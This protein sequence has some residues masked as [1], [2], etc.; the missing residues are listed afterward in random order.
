MAPALA[1]SW[2]DVSVRS[3]LCWTGLLLLS[4]R[5]GS[6]RP[7]LGTVS[8]RVDA[9]VR[10]AASPD[11]TGPDGGFEPG[12]RV[13]LKGT[14][15][16]PDEVYEGEVM[17][18]G[19]FIVCAG[20]G[21]SCSSSAEAAGATVFD[22]EGVIAP[23][24]IDT[25]NHI[26]FD[27]FDDE[28]WLP[29]RSYTNHDMWP[30]EERYAAM[31]DVKQCLEDASQG[32]P[33]WCPAKYDGEGDLKCELNKWGELKGLIAGTTS[34]V[35]LPGTSAACFASLARSV[36]SPQNGLGQDRIQTSA[37]F[38][39]SRSSAD[40]VCA[41][42]ADG[43]TRA[44]LVHAGEGIDA[45][46]LRE[47]DQ[48]GSA[49]TDPGC[50]YDAKT[51]I[52]HGT[53]FTSAQFDAMAAAGM[54][55]T[56]SPASNVA[57]YGTTTDIPSALSAGVTVSLAPDWSMGGSQ[58]MLDELRFANGWDDSVWGDQLSAQDLIV[59]STIN[60]AAVLGLDDQLGRIAVGMRADLA[61]FAGDPSRPYDAIVNAT[62]R[63]VRLV[64]V[65]G[66]SLFGDLSFEGAAPLWP[67]CEHVDICGV[68]KF[69]CAATWDTANKLDQT[70]EEIQAALE[71]ALVELDQV[72]LDDG[73]SFAPPAPI[74]R[75]P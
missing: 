56:W 35:G 1:P 46:A 48:L 50:L 66:E 43:D 58:N 39:P 29:S 8:P 18:Q 32:K 22:T 59:M 34:I 23:G 36:D 55:L 11:A 26:L 72:T 42:F 6:D 65:G 3:W 15:V 74:F 57:L 47:W 54:K 2:Y 38:P 12:G 17:T 9:G 14:V 21:T 52:T 24:L 63:D 19:A 64:M 71:A 61:V 70:F 27:I 62:P 49:S 28:D 68:Q 40:G 5:D 7:D 37:T 33:A 13:L 10:D 31:L 73:Y 41:N 53:A 67:G 51:T 75:C 69:L 4:C 20:A 30:S 60:A 45:S 16:T 44:Y 25:H